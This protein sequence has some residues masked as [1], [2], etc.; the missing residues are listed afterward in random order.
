MR[1]G[2]YDDASSNQME[3]RPRMLVGT[4]S[5]PNVEGSQ[6]HHRGDGNGPGKE[7]RGFFQVEENE[8]NITNISLNVSQMNMTAEGEAITEL[9]EGDTFRPNPGARR[10][11]AGRRQL[12]G[13]GANR[14][15]DLAGRHEAVNQTDIVESRHL[16][17]AN[18]GRIR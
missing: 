16:S 1:S 12:A 10:D 17:Q 2:A 5:L 13:P 8:Q 4:P 11:P 7:G 3:S 18:S 14:R 6:T 9:D 15:D